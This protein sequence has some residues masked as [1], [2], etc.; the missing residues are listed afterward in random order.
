VR[1]VAVITMSCV[2]TG[3]AVVV[4]TVTLIVSVVNAAIR[5][6]S[7]EMRLA[8][9]GRPLIDVIETERF[10][11]MKFVTW[12][13]YVVV[14]PAGTGFGDCVPG[15][16]EMM[17]AETAAGAASVTSSRRLNQPATSRRRRCDK[18]VMMAIACQLSRFRVR[19]PEQERT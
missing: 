18:D 3:V 6:Q 4:P 1:R 15:M 9:A 7:D 16:T 19:A 10:C 17:S 14:M 2:P 5:T 12:T 13:A 8:P 11:P